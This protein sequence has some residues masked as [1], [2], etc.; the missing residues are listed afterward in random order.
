[1]LF[2]TRQLPFP[3]LTANRCGNSAALTSN[4]RC[5]ALW[6]PPTNQPF[7]GKTKIAPHT[8]Y[9]S[10]SSLSPA[11]RLVAS[12]ATDWAIFRRFSFWRTVCVWYC[13]GG[14]QPDDNGRPSNSCSCVRL[15]NA[16]LPWLMYCTNGAN[17]LVADLRGLSDVWLARSP[18]MLSTD[19][20]GIRLIRTVRMKGTQFFFLKR[21]LKQACVLF[22]F[23]DCVS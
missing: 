7:D 2:H 13:S 20:R 4:R 5:I 9:L 15:R 16:S 11:G 22:K 1:M 14:G 17:G 6:D 18:V 10:P 19:K 21:V 12:A 3:S 23:G 8:F